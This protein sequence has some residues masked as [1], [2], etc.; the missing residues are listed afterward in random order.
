MKVLSILIISQKASY[1]AHEA[2]HKLEKIVGEIFNGKKHRYH[3]HFH[4][5]HDHHSSS[6]SESHDSTYSSHKKPYRNDHDSSSSESHKASYSDHKKSHHHDSS[7]SSSSESHEVENPILKKLQ[8]NF[9]NQTLLNIKQLFST[10]Y[11]SLVKTIDQKI[12]D[13]AANIKNLSQDLHL[14]IEKTKESHPQCQNFSILNENLYKEYLKDVQCCVDSLFGN[15]AVLAR[16]F[17]NL[18]TNENLIKIIADS[19][20]GDLAC[21]VSSQDP[22]KCY[23]HADCEVSVNT[24]SL[25]ILIN[26]EINQNS[27]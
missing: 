10:K 7:S 15:M 24:F 19:H 8:R 20:R 27:I 25:H 2:S 23:P 4:H 22:S 13:Q 16:L 1:F 18:C 26:D 5:H 3:S 9:M 6:S 11:S 17:S 21:Y 12:L 14:E